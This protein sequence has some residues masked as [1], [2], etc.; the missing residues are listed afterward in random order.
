MSMLIL[1]IL[2]AIGAIALLGARVFSRVITPKARGILVIVISSTFG[3]G[4]LQ[5]VISLYFSGFVPSISK[6]QHS[7]I[8]I[9]TNPDQARLAFF[10]NIG[11]SIAA[12][13]A[14][15]FLGNYYIRV[16]PPA[17]R[18]VIGTVQSLN[19]LKS[20]NGAREMVSVQLP[21]GEVVT[22]LLA[23]G[24]ALTRGDRVTLI[25]QPRI[26]GNPNYKIATNV[27]GTVA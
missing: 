6:H 17:Q 21:S 8:Q 27:S 16:R 15:I 18:Q 3:I 2:A 22:V 14:G 20:R 1:K 13:I 19:P 10:F 24:G 12:I 5:Y 7:L 23:S 26:L 9:A 11:V 4:W 25:E